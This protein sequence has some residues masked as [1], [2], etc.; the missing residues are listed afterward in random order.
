V[1]TVQYC[2]SLSAMK[3]EKAIC[4]WTVRIEL[5]FVNYENGGTC[6]LSATEAEVAVCPL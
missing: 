1:S 4:P 3:V 5:Q 6:C 2:E